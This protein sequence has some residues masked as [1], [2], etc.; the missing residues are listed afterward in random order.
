M[1]YRCTE[2]TKPLYI[3]LLYRNRLSTAKPVFHSAIKINNNY[4][5]KIY[6][7]NTNK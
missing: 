7:K 2:Y 5:V 6:H 4:W 3:Y 1:I